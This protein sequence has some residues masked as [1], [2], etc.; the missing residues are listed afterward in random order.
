[1]RMREIKSYDSTKYVNNSEYSKV[2]EGIYRNGSHYVTSLS[3]IQEP[4]HE[5]GLNASEI[6][7]FP[8]EDILEEYNCFISDYYDELNVEESVVCYLEFASTELEDIKNLREI[9]G[10]NVYNQ[11][12]K[13]G[14]QVYVD[15]IIS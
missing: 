11:E 7:Q 12:V 4:K 8:L 14:E 15:L 10:K 5:E 6:S 3:F 2:E 9:I 1:M 13:H